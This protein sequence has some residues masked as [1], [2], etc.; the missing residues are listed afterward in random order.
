[1]EG[2]DLFGVRVMDDAVEGWS[3]TRLPFEPKGWLLDYRTKL[4]AALRSLSPVH[5][6]GLAA[7]YHSP[8]D[9]LADV[10]N[11]LCYNIG[12]SCYGHL[13]GGG[14]RMSRGRSHDPLHRVSYRRERIN[15]I[16]VAPLATVSAAVPAGTHSAGQW[17]ALLRPNVMTASPVPVRTLGVEVQVSG[18]WTTPVWPG[19]SSRCWTA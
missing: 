18:R 10:E 14:L 5:G 9:R 19:R 1:M 6:L 17:W 2:A 13:I 11:V 7:R 16:A 15:P 3:V 8:D 4:Q 12:S